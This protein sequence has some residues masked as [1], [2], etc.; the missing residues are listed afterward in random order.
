MLPHIDSVCHTGFFQLRQLRTVRGSLA[1]VPRSM[2]RLMVHSLT[3]SR[4]DYCNSLLFGMGA[5]RI[6]R[7]QYIKNAAARL[8][9]G[10]RKFDRITPVLRNLHWLP[11][12]K[13]IAYKVV[14]LVH[15]CLNGRAPS[16]LADVC[17][18]VDTLPGR[19]QLCYA[20]TG[21]LLVPRTSTNIS[22][23]GFHCCGP[24]TWNALPVSLYVPTTDLL[25]P[26]SAV[27]WLQIRPELCKRCL[28]ASKIHFCIHKM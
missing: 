28:Q 3:S 24:A 2:P 17:I 11:V 26:F 9:S 20:A 25:T 8:V 4:L 7:P 16:Y 19:R 22:R 23:R 5:E 13:R 21:Q 27:A 14:M 18:P 10:T 1:H 12:A 15:K 6:K